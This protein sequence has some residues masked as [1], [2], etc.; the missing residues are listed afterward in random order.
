MANIVNPVDLSQPMNELG[1]VGEIRRDD[2]LLP[3]NDY[4]AEKNQY[5]ATNPDAISDGDLFGKGTG[6][7]LDTANGGS[8]TDKSERIANI[9]SNK[10]KSN[11]V[12]TT[13]SV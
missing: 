6:I 8:S 5:S 11:S 10:Y 4:V 7:F 9:V 12:Y 2:Y 1:K 13:P 3:K